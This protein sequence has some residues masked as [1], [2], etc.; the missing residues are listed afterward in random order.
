MKKYRLKKYFEILGRSIPNSINTKNGINILKKYSDSEKDYE[1]YVK[2]Q[3]EA[4]VAK[5]D[6]MF[7]IEENVKM[8]SNYLK[9]ELPTIK[10]G[11]CHGTRRGKEQEW[12]RK[13]LSTDVIG[14]EISETAIKFPNTIQWDFHKVKKEWLN[15]VDFIYSNSLDHSYDPKFCLTQW[16]SCLKKGGICIIN[17]SGANDP[18]FVNKLDLF[19]FTK[20]GLINF[21]KGLEKENKIELKENYHGK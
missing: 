12:F 17:G 11:I 4:N 9:K 14:T 10:F 19:G 1:R 21:I 18:K 5:I 6:E 16:F 13:Y 8:L 7:E 20:E 2:I 3:T 15:N